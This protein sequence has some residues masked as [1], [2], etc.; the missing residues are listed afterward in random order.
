[1]AKVFLS[2]S[3]SS[4]PLTA[5]LAQDANAQH[6]DESQPSIFCPPES[7]L[8]FS[9]STPSDIWAVGCMVS[10][11]PTCRQSLN[12]SSQAFE[13]AGDYHLFRQDDDFNEAVHIQKIT[14][15]VGKI[16]STFLVD[17]RCG[18]RYFDRE[19]A[20]HMDG[21]RR[22]TCLIFPRGA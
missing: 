11:W 17:C 3:Y 8:G 13:L 2:P 18:S 22:A 12:D 10:S 1:M 6:M 14:E 21:V 4:W 9:W 15:C 19:G 16:P 20:L 7:I 5:R